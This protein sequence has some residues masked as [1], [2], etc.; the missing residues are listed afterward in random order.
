MLITLK[1]N[2]LLVLFY[3]ILDLILEKTALVYVCPVK[4]V[5]YQILG[6]ISF[7]AKL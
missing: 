6:F 5:R 7:T 3:K 2:K 4:Q 1:I